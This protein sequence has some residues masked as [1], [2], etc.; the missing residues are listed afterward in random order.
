MINPENP[1]ASD[2]LE[3][4]E[5][6]E[7]YGEDP[8]GPLPFSEEKNIIVEPPHPEIEDMEGLE[9][10]INERIDVN[11]NSDQMG[12]DIYM[13]AMELLQNEILLEEI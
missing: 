8:N 10:M 2:L 7:Y 6:D 13:E 12:I 3:E 11:R 4:D 1:L 5:T 9:A